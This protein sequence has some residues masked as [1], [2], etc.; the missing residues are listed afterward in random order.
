LLHAG[1]YFLDAAVEF[2]TMRT[3]EREPA[4]A[5]GKET[6][7]QKFVTV[8]LDN[9]AYGRPKVTG[10]YAD[11]HGLVEEHLQGFLDDGWRV[12]SFHGMGG[13]SSP[14]CQGWVAV[15]LEKNGKAS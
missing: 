13:A 14:A 7:V 15:L 1:A 2:D 12:A 3:E 10:C 8:Y 4:L 9:A 6:G 11:R 5:H